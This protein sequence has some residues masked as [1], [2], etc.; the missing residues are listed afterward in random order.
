MRAGNQ[1]TRRRP[2]ATT[3]RKR[4][5]A[6]LVAA[7]GALALTGPATAPSSA[8]E[9][10]E[11]V[12]PVDGYARFSDDFGAPRSDGRTHQGNDIFASKLQPLLSTRAGRI[13]YLKHD[14]GGLSGNMLIVT[15]AEG[16]Q[17]RYVHINNDSPGTDDGANARQWAFVPGIVQGSYVAAGQHIAYLG[18]SGNAETT[19]PHLHFEIRKPDGTVINPYE[20]LLAADRRRPARAVDVAARPGGGHWVLEANGRVHAL[21]GAP[22]LGAPYLGSLARA[23]AATPDGKGFVILDGWGGL[24]RFGSAR[25]GT[26]ASLSGP[27]WS[28]FD[29]A[30]D[31]AITPTGKGLIVLDGWGGVH[32][33]GDAPR[34]PATWWPGFDIARSVAVTASNKG[35]YVLDG[36]GGVHVRGDA[37]QPTG[38]R[39]Y[40]PGWDIARDVVASTS[41]SGYAVFDGWGGIHRLGDIEAPDSSGWSAGSDWRGLSLVGTRYV[42][43]RH[44]AHS[45]VW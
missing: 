14:N 26:L 37:R 4:S 23:I 33:R 24:H 38:A 3:R 40:W 15:D 22:D 34:G 28:G 36:W 2:M 18:D 7:A 20:S 41:G 44:D 12:F 19:P 10:R 27:W 32:V 16:W 6:V 30:R 21:G 9:I 39:H 31:L 8:G 5:L 43:V 13:S 29:I 45:A 17:Y 11:I 1:E 35:V 25:S 42:G